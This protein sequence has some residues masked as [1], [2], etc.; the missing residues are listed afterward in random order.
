MQ[1]ENTERRYHHLFH[2]ASTYDI[3]LLC[4]LLCGAA[5]FKAAVYEHDVI[6]PSQRSAVLSRQPALHVIQQN[7]D[8]YETQCRQ[9][10]SEGVQIIVFPEY[11]LYGLGWTRQTIAPYLE[12]V[13]DPQIVSWSPCDDPL[14]YNDTETQRQLSCMAKGS[15]LYLVVNFG[16]KQPCD[17]TS[18]NCPGDGFFQYSTNLIYDP[19]GKFIA[20]Y[21]KRNL[22]DDE[23]HF[24]TPSK[25]DYTIFTTKFGRFGTFSSNDI[26]FK[27]PARVLINTMNVTNIV[28]PTAWKDELP[29]QAAIEF[30]AAFSVGMHVNLLA[31]NLHLP[32]DGYHGSGI[33][34]PVGTSTN[35]MVFYYDRTLG[36]KGKL[37]VKDVSPIKYTKTEMHTR[38]RHSSMSE[39]RETSKMA[40][41]N[42]NTSTMRESQNIYHDRTRVERNRLQPIAQKQSDLR[43]RRTREQTANQR[44]KMEMTG[45]LFTDDEIMKTGDSE[46]TAVMNHDLYTFNSVITGQ[47]ASINV[48]QNNLCCKGFFEGSFPNQR[49][50]FGAF[51]GIHTYNGRYPLQSCVFIACANSSVSSCGKPTTSASGDMDK[52]SLSGNFTSGNILPEMLVTPDNV[53]LYSVPLTWWFM[54]NGIIIDAGIPGTPLSLSLYSLGDSTN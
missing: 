25:T 21:F 9:A 4:T 30:Q 24:D 33:Y 7:L 3:I 36:S 34:W 13:P 52:M 20:R 37:L 38:E 40:S 51:S 10:E 32:S 2:V 22:Y 48:C 39:P 46:F 41:R 17:F 23:K 50:A 12:F 19:Q 11:G 45:V 35:N 26:M 1:H 54:G 5:S 44:D 15:A 49:L 27:N 47:G 43:V 53:T 18:P 29:L 6:F 42:H 16:S 28:Y 31:A 14:R 8:V